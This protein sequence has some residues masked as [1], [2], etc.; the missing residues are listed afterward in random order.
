[1]GEPRLLP[2]RLCSQPVGSR[3]GFL[4]F[5]FSSV[6]R[7]RGRSPACAGCSGICP[8]LLP[9]RPPLCHPD[10]TLCI[11]SPVVRT[12]GGTIRVARDPG[13][14]PPPSPWG[15]CRRAPR[16]RSPGSRTRTALL[17]PAVNKELPLAASDEWD[18]ASY[19]PH[20]RVWP[21]FQCPDWVMRVS[22]PGLAP[23]TAA[24]QVSLASPASPLPC[25]ASQ[26]PGCLAGVCAGTDVG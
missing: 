21:T 15:P 23:R 25:L 17:G 12:L 5:G 3:G 6:R 13:R 11:P 22:A 26:E 18:C 4:A 7:P 14:A 1:M 19:R 16:T 9:Q 10:T 24:L 2:V 8:P 20:S